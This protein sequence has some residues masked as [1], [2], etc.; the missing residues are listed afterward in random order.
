MSDE[1]VY[2]TVGLI[3]EIHA[4]I[5]EEGDNTEPGVC[6]KKPITSA[7]HYISEGYFG[8]VQKQSTTKLC[9]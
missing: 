6:S 2:P 3:L 4:Q 9:T 7:V 8:E 1:L 5:V